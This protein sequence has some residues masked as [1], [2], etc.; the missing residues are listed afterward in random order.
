MG[1]TGDGTNDAPALKEADVGLAMGISGTEVAKE[2]ADIIVLDDNFRSVV[3]SVVW[4]RSVFYSLRKFIT[5]QLTVNFVAVIVE[6]VSAA[7]GVEA[8][9]VLQLMWV[10]LIMDSMAAL[11]LATEDPDEKLLLMKPNDRQERIINW[12]MWR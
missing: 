11:A 5:F 2:A 12:N 7:A 8:L 6:V 1:V 10:N 9:T 3:R 4:G